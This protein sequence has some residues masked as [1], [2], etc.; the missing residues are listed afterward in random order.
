MNAFFENTDVLRAKH[1]EKFDCK[2]LSTLTIT[3]FWSF[4]DFSRLGTAGFGETSP[5]EGG[6]GAGGDL[7][8]AP[9]ALREVPILSG[10]S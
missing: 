2:H 9:S 5:P 3:I 7:D 4:R 8:Q 10:D 1:E 6:Y